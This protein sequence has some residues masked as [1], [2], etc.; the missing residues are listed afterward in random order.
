MCVQTRGG[1]KCEGVM[2]GEAGVCRLF[3]VTKGLCTGYGARTHIMSQ[4]FVESHCQNKYETPYQELEDLNAETTR[5]GEIMAITR[6]PLRNG[7][8]RSLTD[9]KKQVSP[10]TQAAIKVTT[11]YVRDTT[12]AKRKILSFGYSMY[13]EEAGTLLQ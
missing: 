3:V 13:S 12:W 9:I 10:N 6:R 1:T 2:T 8:V 5:T 11:R 7:E 4:L